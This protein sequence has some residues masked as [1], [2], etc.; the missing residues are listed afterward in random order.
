MGYRTAATHHYAPT[1]ANWTA[2]RHAFTTT[3]G[4]VTSSML[5][6]RAQK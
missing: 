6:S 5:M 1:N 4:I 3:L 2:T